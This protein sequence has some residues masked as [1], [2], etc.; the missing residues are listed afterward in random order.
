VAHLVFVRPVNAP[1]R[2]TLA[3]AA[4]LVLTQ[5][6]HAQIGA[7]REELVKNYGP[8]EQNPHRNDKAPN[9]YD[10]VLDVGADCTFQDGPIRFMALFKSDRALG[11]TFTKQR[12]FW[13][14]LLH[15]SSY[16]DLPL[17]DTEIAALLQK[18]DP[19]GEWVAQPSDAVIRRWRTS[20]GSAAAY[21][22][23]AGNNELYHLIVQ[24]AAVDEIF[25]RVEKY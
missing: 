5:L 18:A 13:D 11:F 8:C 17:S 22:F 2:S 6:G 14:S 16:R 24:T 1:R 19:S 25:R 21:Y 12:S 20:D 7:T 9:V 15:F 23:A 10:G 3:V 4:L